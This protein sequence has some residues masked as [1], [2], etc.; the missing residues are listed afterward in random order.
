MLSFLRSWTIFHYFFWHKRSRWSDFVRN[1]FHIVKQRRAQEYAMEIGIRIRAYDILLTCSMEDLDSGRKF[2]TLLHCRHVYIY[3]TYVMFST[4]KVAEIGRWESN[5]VLEFKSNRLVPTALNSYRFNL[6]TNVIREVKDN[7]EIYG[8][9]IHSVKRFLARW[10]I[11]NIRRENICGVQFT[12]F[13]TAYSQ[14]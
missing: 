7:N 3:G 11:T 10:T 14:I 8:E 1:P 4:G 5:P 13:M 9:K 12:V 2:E 6:Q